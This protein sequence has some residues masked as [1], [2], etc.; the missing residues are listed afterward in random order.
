MDRLTARDGFGT[1]YY[2]YC[3]NVKGCG[4]YC[5]QCN[6]ETKTMD[7][8][9]QYEDLED[10][11]GIPMK[12][13]AEILRQNIPEDCKHPHKAIVL[14]DDDVDKWHVYKNAEEQG[15]LLRLYCNVGDTV[16]CIEDKKIWDCIV[17]KV[18]ISRTN[19]VWFEVKTPK[20]MPDISAIE[21]TENAFGET[22]FLTQAEAE[23]KLKEMNTDNGITE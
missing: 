9:A 19:G 6:F 18:T 14:T 12:D 4:G 7:K 23:Q 13:L 17:D 16:Y 8:L 22:V 3:D 21:Y 15:L 10:L 20:S 1:P 2:P 5:A 11:I